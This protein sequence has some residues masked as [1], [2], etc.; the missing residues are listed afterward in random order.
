MD[1]LSFFINSGFY[2]TRFLI[3]SFNINVSINN[4]TLNGVNAPNIKIN[5]AKSLYG[6]LLPSQLKELSSFSINFISYFFSLIIFLFFCVMLYLVCNI[7]FGK[8]IFETF[9]HNIS[10]Y[11]S[12]IEKEIVKINN[13]YILLLTIILYFSYYFLFFD[14][15]NFLPIVWN[16]TI[17]FLILLTIVVLFIPIYLLYSYGFYF[18]IYIRGSSLKKNF[19]F[20][21]LMDILNLLSF[22]LRINIQFI[23]VLLITFVFITY[24]EQYYDF[25]YPWYNTFSFSNN[26]LNNFTD[27]V[28]NSLLIIIS[29]LLKFLYELTHF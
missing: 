7:I 19:F 26:N 17:Y 2:V 10:I 16:L 20:E 14:D 1:F 25:V 11:T 18:L 22:F 8:K 23:R 28:F 6:D 9:S 24:D 12:K 4:E 15:F 21:L 3:R 13:I 27:Y 29:F 5:N